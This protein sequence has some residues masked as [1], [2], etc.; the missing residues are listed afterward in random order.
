MLEVPFPTASRADLVIGVLF[1]HRPIAIQWARAFQN[2]EHPSYLSV[3]TLAIQNH[4]AR[5]G[6]NGGYSFAEVAAS[7]NTIAAQAVRMGAKISVLFG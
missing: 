3:Q 4:I 1:C 5:T 7:R 6:E 2:I